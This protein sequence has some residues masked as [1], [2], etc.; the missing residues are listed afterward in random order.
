MNVFPI[1]FTRAQKIEREA[2]RRCKEN[3]SLQYLELL[4]DLARKDGFLHWHHVC[5]CRDLGYQQKNRLQLPP[6]MQRILGEA[7]ARF[8]VSTTAQQAFADGIVVAVDV[9]DVQKLDALKNFVEIPDVW[10]LAAR[11]IWPASLFGRQTERPKEDESARDLKVMDDFTC[12]R[13]FAISVDS[14]DDTTLKSLAKLQP[15]P[16]QWCW[17]KGKPTRVT[18]APW[19]GPDRPR[20]ERFWHLIDKVSRSFIEKESPA[21]ANDSAFLVEKATPLGQL[22]YQAVSTSV[23]MSWQQAQPVHSA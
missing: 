9:A 13:F 22:R 21:M 19:V 12:L 20:L 1:S 7:K 11:D 3:P 14:G 6:R 8:P 5:L 17:I 4:E 23:S 2:K 18:N 16:V 10:H 15:A